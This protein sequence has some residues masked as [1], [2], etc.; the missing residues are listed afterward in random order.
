V[1][2]NIDIVCDEKVAKVAHVGKFK[3]FLKLQS[4]FFFFFK[5]NIKETNGE[6]RVITKKLTFGSFSSLF[7]TGKL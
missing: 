6:T 2:L 3:E 1:F 7:K 4:T 5:S